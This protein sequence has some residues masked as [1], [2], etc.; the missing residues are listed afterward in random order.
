MD[1]ANTGPADFFSH[2]SLYFETS[3]LKACNN[4]LYKKK[5]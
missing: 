1:G 5:N 2:I 3:I 4:F